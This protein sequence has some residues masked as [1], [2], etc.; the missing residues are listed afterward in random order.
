LLG[1]RAHHKDLLLA[2]TMFDHPNNGAFQQVFHFLLSVLLPERAR[3]E[4]RDCWP[5]LDR[6]QEAEFRR[7]VV[8][9]VKEVAKERQLPAVNPALFM[10]PGG[11]KFKAFLSC[12]ATQAVRSRLEQGGELALGRPSCRGRARRA[13]CHRLARLEAAAV[14]EAVEQQAAISSM[15]AKAK[16]AMVVM[17]ADYIELKKELEELEKEDYQKIIAEA[18]PD[19]VVEGRLDEE[20]ALQE[21]DCRVAAVKEVKDE[22]TQRCEATSGHCSN[23]RGGLEDTLPRQQL[24]LT[25][26]PREAV[27]PASLS[28]TYAALLARGRH[29]AAAA[30]ALAAPR[31]AGPGL[32]LAAAAARQQETVLHQLKGELA[33]VVAEVGSSVKERLR[34]S[35]AVDWAASP[36]APPGRPAALLLPPTPR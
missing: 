16:D 22:F 30:L 7:K 27:D 3:D 35:A 31:P 5:V 23:I 8:G 18:H 21:Y 33:A 15:E 36:L 25:G 11:P 14:E 20:K 13:C 12:L 19:L 2:R 1:V 24:D 6:K 26:L 32:E 34:E 4:F 28:A 29:S 17:Q 9:L 10:A